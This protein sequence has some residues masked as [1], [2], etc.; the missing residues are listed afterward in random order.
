[1]MIPFSAKIGTRRL[2]ALGI[3]RAGL[4]IPSGQW[5]QDQS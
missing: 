2:L 3:L 5:Q 4:P 1:M